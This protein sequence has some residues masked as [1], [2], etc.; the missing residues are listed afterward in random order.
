MAITLYGS[1]RSRSMRVLWMAAEL[2]LTF[3]HVPYEF[4][5]PKLK[6]AEFLAQNPAGA[7]PTLVDDEFVISE[8]LA[9]N[10]YL[11]RK[12]GAAS[13][14]GGLTLEDDSSAV[15]W[16]LFAQ[17]HLEPWLQQ[18]QIL[19][20]AMLAIGDRCDA[21]VQH[22]LRTL[23]AVLA[24]NA[25]LL[26]ERFTV[27]DLN[28]AGVLS[29]SRS[30]GLDFSSCPH[31]S[32]WLTACYARPAALAVRARYASMQ[33]L[34]PAAAAS[35]EA[36]PQIAPA[37]IERVTEFL[38]AVD[39]I[40]V[41]I[42]GGWGVD[43]LLGEQ[44]RE[45]ADVDIIISVTDRERLG[46]HLG[47]QGYVAGDTFDVLVSPTGLAVDIH[48]VRFDA[49][50]RGGFALPNGGSWVLPASAFAGIGE[51]GGLAVQCLSPEAQVQCHAQGY[52]PTPRDISDMAALQARFDVVLPLALCQSR[53]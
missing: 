3:N 48:C 32:R 13:D 5:D 10:L 42:D 1:P 11:A 51:I 30:Q 12:Y 14:L 18:D 24:R 38:Q 47:S 39:G 19:A 36:T 4:D 2:D 7:I 15:R 25:W 29:P 37:T 26:G 9:I 41:W 21:V 35:E 34:E 45:H 8:S 28:V 49:Q 22:A 33:P 27:A 31:V 50:G 43:A 23:D 40:D 20:D 6:S 52:L 44:R 17:G 46:A 53:S 16:S